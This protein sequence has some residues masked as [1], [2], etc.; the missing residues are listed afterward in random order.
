MKKK[1][2]LLT[3]AGLLVLSG[4]SASLTPSDIPQPETPFTPALL[5]SP[6]SKPVPAPDG[7]PTGASTGA[8][9]LPQPVYSGIYSLEE[10]LKKRRSIRSYSGAYLTLAEVS[11]L[12]WAAQ[13]LTDAGGGR[14][15]PS[16]GALYPLEVYLTASR[17]EDLAAGVYRYRPADHGLAP[18]KQ[19]NIMSDLSSAA[20]SQPAVKNAPV[21][22]IIAAVYERTAKKYGDRAERYAIL[23]AGHAAQNVCLQAVALDLGVVTIGAF[24]DQRVKKAIGLQD[25][26]SP[27]YLLPVGHPE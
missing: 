14:T 1:L 21:C 24:D 10:C 7:A 9:S 25:S 19:G 22:L 13:G 11:Q 8:I 12:L 5:S 18:L 16:A 17:V 3:I 6:V 4:C 26:E 20:L 15:A 2:G 23:E 27:L